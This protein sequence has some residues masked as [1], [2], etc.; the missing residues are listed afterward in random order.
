MEIHLKDMRALGNAGCNDFT[1]AIKTV[2]N[3]HLVFG[4]IAGTRKLCLNMDIPDARMKRL[5]QVQQYRLENLRLQLLDQQ[6]QPLL[7]FRKVD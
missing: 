7:R 5:Q 1:G 3:Q 6:G 2:D 4:T